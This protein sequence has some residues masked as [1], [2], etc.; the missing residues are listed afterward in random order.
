MARRQ[1]RRPAHTDAAARPPTLAQAQAAGFPVGGEPLAVDLADTLITATD[2]PTDLLGDDERARAFW[3]FQAW[4]LPPGSAAPSLAATRALRA[5]SRA[6]LEARLDGRQPP[7]EA[8]AA[9]N[10]AVAAAPTSP[11]L[12][13]G[14]HGLAAEERW[15]AADS[16]TWPLAAA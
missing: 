13:L 9:V 7:A 12:V 15:H 11:H 10:A 16:R 3:A 8:V 4:R 2:P 14:P 1:P 5:A 6:L